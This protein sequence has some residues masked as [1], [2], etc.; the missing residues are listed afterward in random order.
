MNLRVRYYGS[1]EK[2]ETFFLMDFFD[3][4]DVMNILMY[5]MTAMVNTY[6]VRTLL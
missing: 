6:V 2:D 4:C 3:F 5:D 1:E